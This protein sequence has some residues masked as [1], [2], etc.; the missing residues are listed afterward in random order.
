[1]FPRQIASASNLRPLAALP[2]YLHR[3]NFEEKVEQCVCP[4]DGLISLINRLRSSAAK[5]RRPLEREKK[6]KQ[7]KGQKKK[8]HSR[9][10]SERTSRNFPFLREKEDNARARERN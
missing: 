3:L 7:K 2:F 8:E 9:E 5:I 4:A 10:Q 1:M 6:E